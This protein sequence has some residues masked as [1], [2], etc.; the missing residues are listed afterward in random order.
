MDNQHNFDAHDGIAY[1]Q[2]FAQ[3]FPEDFDMGQPFEYD[4]SL[5]DPAMASN[6]EF[7]FSSLAQLAPMC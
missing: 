2:N 1:G 6:S 7:A 5:T 3:G 4:P